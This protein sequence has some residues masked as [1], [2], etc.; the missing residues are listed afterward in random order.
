MDLTDSGHPTVEALFDHLDRW[1]HFAGFPLETRV[2][3]LFGLFL[4]K[5]IEDCCG[6]EEMD[7]QVIPQFPLK[8]TD[9]NQSYKVDFFANSR[10]S[11]RRFLIELKTDMGSRREGQ[12]DYLR[13]AREKGMA[14]ILS[15]FKEIAEA[16]K[17][18]MKYFHPINA[19]S[20][21]GLFRLSKELKEKIRDG[22]TRGSSRLIREIEV[23]LLSDSK[24]EVI[25]VQPRKADPTDQTDFQYIYFDRF[26]DCIQSYGELGCLFARYLRRWEADPGGSPTERA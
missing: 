1:R 13:D 15:D 5:V 10:D 17:S 18:R 22:T 24:A 4:P 16:S 19:L 12:Y 3:V 14:R 2:D 21:M 11:E 25:F 26:A 8:K 9:N 23:C 20:E 6:L 7:P